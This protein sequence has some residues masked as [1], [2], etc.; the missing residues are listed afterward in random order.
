MGLK[1]RHHT[2]GTCWSK[3][4]KESPMNLY[5]GR[6]VIL[7]ILHRKQ[8]APK[9]TEQINSGT[10]WSKM[11]TESPTTRLC[12]RIVKSM[13]LRVLACFIDQITTSARQRVDSNSR[14]SSVDLSL[15]LK[16]WH[17]INCNRRTK[18]V[19][20]WPV[21][22][23]CIRYCSPYVTWSRGVSRMSQ[24]LLLRYKQW[25]SSNPFIL[26]CFEGWLMAHNSV[27]VY[28]I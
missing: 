27:T 3:M 25:K 6:N 28:P 17:F 11:L 20:W 15:M 12:N 1:I 26:H 22:C 21:F 4:L 16:S 2:I 24:I 8:N 9:N 5:H 18:G 7:C 23:W 13:R 14:V 10:S 19:V